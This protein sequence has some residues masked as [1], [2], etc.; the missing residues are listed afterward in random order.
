MYKVINIC[1][2][3]GNFRI[4]FMTHRAVMSDASQD[5]GVTV[6]ISHG[7]RRGNLPEAT[8]VSLVA[9]GLG[10]PLTQ[11]LKSFM[12]S[13]GIGAYPCLVVDPSSGDIQGSLWALRGARNWHAGYKARHVWGKEAGD[14]GLVLNIPNDAIDFPADTQL[15]CFSRWQDAFL[16]GWA[17][18]V[19]KDGKV[20][21]DI[22]G[23]VSRA[24]RPAARGGPAEAAG[25]VRL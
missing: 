13:D 14:Y 9:R 24:D 7:F 16:K 12:P 5:Q 10:E 23:L 22:S 18:I 25:L 17:H 20:I 21:Q 4:Q 2:W 8:K 3:I 1:L 6:V 19:D 15:K 11:T